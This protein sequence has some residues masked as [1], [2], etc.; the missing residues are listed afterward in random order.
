[1]IFDIVAALFIFFVILPIVAWTLCV[2][3]VAVGSVIKSGLTRRASSR[4]DPNSWSASWTDDDLDQ[5]GRW[6]PGKGGQQ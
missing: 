2:M 1:M 4:F 6:K 3:L 5:Y